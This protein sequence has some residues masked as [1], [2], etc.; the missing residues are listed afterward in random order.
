MNA[1]QTKKKQQKHIL[2][3]FKIQVHCNITLF[4]HPQIPFYLIE[5]GGAGEG[6]KD[7]FTIQGSTITWTKQQLRHYNTINRIK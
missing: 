6:W 5:V 7:K 1:K 3:R 2:L 4:S